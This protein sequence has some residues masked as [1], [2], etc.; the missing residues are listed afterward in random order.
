MQ[1]DPEL[2]YAYYALHELNI[3]PEEFARMS[4]REKAVLMAFIDLRVQERE[5]LLRDW[6]A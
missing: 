5:R 6:M 2:N 1:G 3:R 4:R